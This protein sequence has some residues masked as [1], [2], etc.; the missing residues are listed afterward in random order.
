[1]K[2]FLLFLAITATVVVLVLIG[3]VA[4]VSR[5]NTVHQ[6]LID[7]INKAIPGK[8]A[9]KRIAISPL[10]IKIE[11]N[12]FVLAD[13]SGK[14]LAGIQRLY[15]NV[16][17]LALLRKKVLVRNASIEYPRVVLDIDSAGSISLLKALSDGSKQSKSEEE[18]KSPPADSFALP[19][20]IDIQKLSILNGDIHFAA[21]HQNISVGAH[22]LSIKAS[23][24]SRTLSADLEVS[25]DS[26]SLGLKNGPI[27][28]YELLFSARMHEMNL[29]TVMVSGRTAGSSFSIKG[30]AKAPFTD[31]LIHAVLAANIALLEVSAI[32]GNDLVLDGATAIN[33]EFSGRIGNPDKARLFI[34]SRGANIA[35]YKIDSLYCATDLQDRVVHIAPLSIDAGAGSVAINGNVDARRFF[36]DGFTGKQGSLQELAYQMEVKAERILLDSLMKGMSGSANVSLLLNGKG[37]TPD[38]ITADV[39]MNAGIESFRLDSLKQPL[40]ATVAC[41]ATVKDGEAQVSRFN[42][43]FGETELALSG[44]YHIPSGAVNGI[45]DVNVPSIA[46]LLDCVF[47]FDSLEGRV[48]LSGR[49]GGDIRHPEAQ[50]DLKADSIVYKAMPAG[51]IGLA[52]Q[53]DSSGIATVNKLDVALGKSRIYVKGNARVLDNGAPVDVQKIA[54]DCSVAAPGIFVE[55]FID[56]VTACIE[57]EGAVRGTISD[58]HGRVGIKAED[59]AAAGQ[60]IERVSLDANLEQQRVLIEPLE[61]S[62][63]PGAALSV[64]GWA[65]VKDSFDLRLSSSN[66][67]LASIPQL[68][69]A[70]DSLCGTASVSIHAQGTYKQP[71]AEGKIAVKKIKYGMYPIDDIDLQFGFENQ[72]LGIKGTAIA[73]LDGF[74]DLS[75]KGFSLKADLDSI[76]LRPFLAMTGQQLDGVLKTAIHLSGTTDSLEATT[77]EM[78]IKS[79]VINYNK[80]KIVETHDLRMELVNK[81]YSVP[82]FSIL[83]AGEGKINGHAS[84]K[85]D[86]A[87]DAMLKGIVPLTVVQYFAPDLDEIEGRLTIDAFFNGTIKEHTLKAELRPEGIGMA[88]PGISQ[89]L[90]SLNGLI[91]ATKDEVRIE[92]LNA[93]I[94]NGAVRAKGNL[95]LDELSPSDMM[96]DLIMEAVP[97]SLPGMLDMT[98]NANLRIAGTPDTTIA[99]GTVV[100]LDGLYYQDIVINPFASMGQKRKRKEAL[101]PAEITLPYMRNMRF[102]VDLSGRTPFRVDNNMAQLYINPDLQLSGTLAAPAVNGRAAVE[103]GTISYLKRVFTVEK[104]V[105]DFVNPYAIEPKIDIR[106]T[107]P[108]QERIIQLTLSGNIDDLQFSLSSNDPSLEDQDIV[109]LL[110]LGKTSTELQSGVMGGQSTEQMLAS[111]VASTFGDDIKK[112][113]GLDVI[114]VETGNSDNAGSDRIAVTVGKDIT[115]RLRTKYTVES[116]ASVIV[117]RATAEYRILQDLLLSGYQDTRGVN[118]AELRFIW[119]RR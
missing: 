111:L 1:M 60:T 65:S 58:L 6:A 22:G 67:E 34:L 55:D 48:R 57:I 96:A 20:A 76:Q 52:A 101:P 41:S 62:L 84:G 19:M 92:S 51:E 5:S 91:V 93:G 54:F 85:I 45:L 7:Q 113:T 83:L 69:K 18:S 118:G 28:L 64:T 94:G 104:G 56:S 3:A 105:I 37:V 33:A 80:E 77:G 81:Q 108:V 107:V 59:I 9:I 14:E 72:R 66:I 47:P 97:V 26:L 10:A 40:N 2:R 63:F 95:K 21:G 89:R 32:I 43:A 46:A 79:L 35:G 73:M 44:S 27:N 31:P 4:L 11:I 70:I 119:E 98:L 8:F 71:G 86:G 15:L 17:S 16:S 42:A 90:H 13:S 102:N 36:L 25:F 103:Q 74:Y 29:D 110:V 88:I 100:L 12:D 24:Q 112:A 87:H 50:L 49:V 106:G 115:R 61:I 23:G 117:Q 38:S 109:L 68:S 53:L 78:N 114:E 39:A 116:E 82:D 30:S 99:S 75:N